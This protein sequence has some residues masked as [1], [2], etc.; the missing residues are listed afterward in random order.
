MM[1]DA[2][3]IDQL[4][5]RAKKAQAEL[6]T[7]SQEKIDS[8]VKMFGKVIFDNAVELSKIA[9]EETR[10]GVYEDKVAKCQGKSRIIWNNLKGKKSVGILEE[11]EE[12]GLVIMA[13]P[14]GVV[15]AVTPCTN[16]IVTPMCNAMFAI[17]GAN[18][19]IIAP[20]PRGKKG[21]KRIAELYYEQLDKMGVP[22]DIFLVIEE[23][24]IE[25]TNE[26]MKKVNVVIATGGAGMV[27]AAYS[28]GK[29][30]FGVGPGNVQGIIDRDVDIK[31]AAS[32]MIA[33]RIFDNGVIC[34]GTQTIIAPREKFD[35]VINEFK[36]QGC[37]YVYD[38]ERVDV[39]RKAILPNGVINKD[40]VGQSVQKIAELAGIDV[41][42]GT[43]VIIL[44]P[45]AYGKDDLLSKEKM[46][47]VMT[48]YEYDEWEDAVEI[49]YQNLMYEGAGHSVDIQS[50][51]DEH[52]NYAGLKLP[53]S[54]LV[55]NQI[56]ATMAGGAF[57]N[58]LSPTTTL[59]CGSWGNN[60]ISENLSYFHLFNKSRIARVKPG[61]KQPSDA[62][63]WE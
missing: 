3:L 40:A 31:Q 18:A 43:K 50:N 20:H 10:M 54:R 19:I 59:G 38:P 51:D 39:F 23:P 33:S 34:S 22:R 13:K 15:G 62:E 28:S 48:A 60:S 55:V 41:P 30:S 58:S 32:N 4:V 7:Y 53:L 5:E 44:K 26:L 63:I 56:C 2:M 61:W 9:I 16:P 47:P 27:K 52:I 29:P 57:A 35:E 14:M 17:K 8:I 42:E 21:A 12:A 45:D 6:A 36:S 37:Y 1:E 24:S 49:A 25:L 46:C 11:D